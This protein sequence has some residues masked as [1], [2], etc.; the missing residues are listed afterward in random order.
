M[1]WTR[2]LLAW[3]LASHGRARSIRELNICRPR[4]MDRRTHVE[5]RGEYEALGESNLLCTKI[6]PNHR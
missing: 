5:Y 6:G 1:T 4:K 3:F 2:L